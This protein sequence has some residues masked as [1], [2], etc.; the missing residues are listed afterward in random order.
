MDLADRRSTARE[1]PPPPDWN[2]DEPAHT[3]AA[4]SGPDSGPGITLSDVPG[5][6]DSVR[7]V[8]TGTPEP[9]SVLAGRIRAARG[10]DD[11]RQV[12]L[13]CWSLLV[14]LPRAVLHLASWALEHP[15]RTAA[16]ALVLAGLIGSLTL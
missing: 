9:L 16:V 8:W 12:A 4:D 13:A 5:D 7:A 2:P 10:A 15:L 11:P 14:L 3:V 1:T 6:W